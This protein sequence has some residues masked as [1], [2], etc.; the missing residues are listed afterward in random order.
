MLPSLQYHGSS[1][2]LIERGRGWVQG[3][4]REQATQNRFRY[5]TQTELS[6]SGSDPAGVPSRGG[7][8]GGTMEI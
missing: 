7:E 4:S 6:L 8:V 2:L 5:M 1:N 3:V